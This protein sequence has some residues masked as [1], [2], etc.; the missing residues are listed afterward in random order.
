MKKTNARYLDFFDRHVSKMIYDKYGIPEI[1]SIR[2]FLSSETYKML[3][4]E[5]TEVYTM[6]PYAVFDMWECE[7]VQGNPRASVYIREE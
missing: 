4:T 5:E 6:S 7:K 3:A 1:E 2:T